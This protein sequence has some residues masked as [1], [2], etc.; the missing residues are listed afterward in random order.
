MGTLVESWCEFFIVLVILGSGVLGCFVF[1]L[2]SFFNSSQMTE[3]KYS[4]Q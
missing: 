3:R 4:V 1:V 2:F